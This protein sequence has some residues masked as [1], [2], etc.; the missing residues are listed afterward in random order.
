MV[1]VVGFIGDCR[2]LFVLIVLIDVFLLFIKL[3]ENL[4]IWSGGIISGFF[5][6]FCFGWLNDLVMLLGNVFGIIFGFC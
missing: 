1:V 6:R 3:L 2:V 5:I 4:L